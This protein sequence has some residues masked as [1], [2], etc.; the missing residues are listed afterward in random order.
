MEIGFWIKTYFH[1]RHVLDSRFLFSFEFYLII[2]GWWKKRKHRVS[3][4]AFGF[5]AREIWLAKSLTAFVTQKVLP[6]EARFIYRYTASKTCDHATPWFFF[7]LA[8]SHSSSFFFS[9]FP[10]LPLIFILYSRKSFIDMHSV[11]SL[12]PLFL[13]LPEI[14]HVWRTFTMIYRTEK[15]SFRRQWEFSAKLLLCVYFSCETPHDMH[16]YGKSGESEKLD[17]LSDEF[18]IKSSVRGENKK[19]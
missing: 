5:M 2:P 19:K 18:L 10:L 12:S 4:F 17:C 7:L 9:F 16:L 14:W 3:L 1:P 11:K 6:L 8:F 15:T 13:S